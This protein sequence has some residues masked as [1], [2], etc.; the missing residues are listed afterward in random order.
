M[1]ALQVVADAVG[2]TDVSHALNGQ[3]EFTGRGLSTAE[4]WF[5]GVTGSVRIVLSVVGAL[6]GGG[7]LLDGLGGASEETALADGAANT[8]EGGQK[9]GVIAPCFPHWGFTGLDS[10][11]ERAKTG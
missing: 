4:R 1:A 9:K 7:A 5:K 10:R 11:L 6:D 8:L 3:E 2:A